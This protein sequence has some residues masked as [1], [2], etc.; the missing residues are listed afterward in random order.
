MAE[1]AGKLGCKQNHI[2]QIEQGEANP[3][4]AFLEKSAEVYNLLTRQ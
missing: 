3:P 2:T 1:A 4:Q